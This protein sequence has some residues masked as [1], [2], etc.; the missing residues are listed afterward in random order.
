MITFPL[1]AIATWLAVA[2]IVALAV[3]GTVSVGKRR[4]LSIAPRAVLI[5]IIWIVTVAAAGCLI[6]LAPVYLDWGRL[7]SL[8]KSTAAPRSPRQRLC[9]GLSV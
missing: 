6:F 8:I 4:P 9:G 5:G 1:L 3:V 2:V 7:S